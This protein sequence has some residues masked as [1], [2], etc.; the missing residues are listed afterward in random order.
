VLAW[1]ALRRLWRAC[2]SVLGR[3]GGLIV[4]L[5]SGTHMESWWRD[6][7][8]ELVVLMAGCHVYSQP[9]ECLRCGRSG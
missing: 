2:E 6:W 8:F 4:V 1:A 9:V 3:C 7:E 5:I